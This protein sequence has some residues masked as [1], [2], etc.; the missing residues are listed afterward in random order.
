MTAVGID[1]I[2][3]WLPA[4]RTPIRDLGE[5]AGLAEPDRTLVD[6]FGIAS[7]PDAGDRHGTDLAVEAVRALLARTGLRP[8]EVDALLF[9]GGRAPEYLMASESTRVQHE[10]GLSSALSFSVS[11]LGCASISTAL[12]TARSLLLSTSDWR[13]VVIAHGCVRPGPGRIRLPVTVNGDAGLA[14]LMRPLATALRVVDVAV[15]TDGRFWDLFRVEYR[16][17]A[18]EHWREVCADP[19]RYSFELAI[20]SR[21]RLDRLN[22]LVLDRNGLAMSDV[23]HVLMQNVSTGAFRFYEEAFDVEIAKVCERNLAGY[24]HL[25]PVDV[26]AN[27]DAG[28]TSGQFEPGDLVLVMNNSPAAAW[29]SMLVE[30]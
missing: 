1:A 30:V 14:V 16:G 29:S 2:E 28:V 24:G 11:D 9:I 27:L 21:N 10:T 19:A 7:V 13:N 26:M 5:Y 8:G 15:E 18:P 3:V 12:L 6:G 23:D 25:G 20:E 4:D 22:R 17:L